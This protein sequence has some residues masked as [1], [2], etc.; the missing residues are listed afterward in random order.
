MPFFAQIYH[1][2]AHEVEFRHNHA[3]NS[4]L[5]E[6]FFLRAQDALH[7]CNPYVQQFKSAIEYVSQND[8]ANELRI[9]R[10][11]HTPCRDLHRGTV[12]L[13]SQDSNV[14]VIAPGTTPTE[15]FGKLAVTTSNN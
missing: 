3:S 1:D 12:N 2:P 7:E 15:Q 14:A 11:A 4:G 10:T 8:T 6:E 13:P 9:V 5:N